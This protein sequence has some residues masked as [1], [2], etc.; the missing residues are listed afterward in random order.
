MAGAGGHVAALA[1]SPLHRFSKETVDQV[2][3]IA[4]E[5]VAGDAHSGPKVRHRSRVR[6]DPH[7]PNLRQVLLIAGELLDEMN[8]LGF[9]VEPGALGENIL[10]CG[11][12]LIVLP[13]GT[14]VLFP[15]GAELEITG[16]RN[17]CSQIET[18]R[19]GLLAQVVHKQASGVIGRRAGVMAIVLTGGSVA[20][21]DRV[22]LTFPDP[23]HE[24][25]EA[26]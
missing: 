10:T 4:G 21:G 18:F 25:L 19:P 2:M 7:Q 16:L 15:S 24:Q 23:P 12:D 20:V 13:R 9:A 11:I 5:G 1:L 3:L 8:G 14:R 17:P 26:V 6:Q 22:G